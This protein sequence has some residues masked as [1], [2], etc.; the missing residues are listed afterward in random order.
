MT[1]ELRRAQL[2]PA[3]ITGAEDQAQLDRARDDLVADDQWIDDFIKRLNFT[4]KD[5]GRNP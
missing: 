5:I 4:I 2:P 3:G 1:P